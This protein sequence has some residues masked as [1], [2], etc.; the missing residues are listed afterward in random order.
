MRASMRSAKGSRCASHDPPDGTDG[1]REYGPAKRGMDPLE[2][3]EDKGQI[4]VRW[5]RFKPD[6]AEREPA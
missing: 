3:F 6:I 4:M 1:T 2:V 5:Q